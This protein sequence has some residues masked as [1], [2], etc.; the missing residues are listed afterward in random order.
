MGNEG[1]G[2]PCLHFDQQFKY[3][4]SQKRPCYLSPIKATFRSPASSVESIRVFIT[5]NAAGRW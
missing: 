4:S 2:M 1:V 5:S 3:T